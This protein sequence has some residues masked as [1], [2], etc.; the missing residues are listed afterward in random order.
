VQLLIGLHKNMKF[1]IT[2]QPLGITL[3]EQPLTK[4]MTRKFNMPAYNGP[5]FTLKC[6]A[7]TT[8]AI[9]G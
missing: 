6:T 4:I 7:L 9:I 5:V 1:Q 3:M 2:K 8:Y